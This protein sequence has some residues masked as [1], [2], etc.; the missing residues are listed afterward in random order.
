MIQAIIK[1]TKK[2]TSHPRKHVLL[3]KKQKQKKTHCATEMVCMKSKN[4][5]YKYNT[6]FVV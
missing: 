6:L 2:K 3:A 4:N 5:K 1:K